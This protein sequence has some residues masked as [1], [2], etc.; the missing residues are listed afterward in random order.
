MVEN[1]WPPGH[2]VV[3]PAAG[4]A[5]RAELPAMGVFMTSAAGRWG[6]VK[7]NGCQSGALVGTVALRAGQ[8]AMCAQ[9]DEAR[10]IMVERSQILP[11]PHRVA[12]FTTLVQTRKTTIMRA[13]MAGF[14]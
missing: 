7:G 10:A 13:A 12:R 11:R 6:V 14:A 5:A 8:R 4:R 9:Q 3:A 2:V 1:R